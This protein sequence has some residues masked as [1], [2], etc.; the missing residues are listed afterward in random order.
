MRRYDGDQDFIAR[1]TEASLIDRLSFIKRTFPHVLMMGSYGPVFVAD[2]QNLGYGSE[3]IKSINHLVSDTIID[4]PDPWAS[5]DLIISNLNLQWVNDLPGFLWQIR[6]LLKPD[7]LFI[8]SLLGGD[9]LKELK[10]S[11]LQ[12]EMELYSGASA[13]VI[14]MVDLYSASQLLLRADFKL[15]VADRDMVK[16]SYP[17]LAKL[18][19]DLRAMGLTNVMHNRHKFMSSRRFFQRAEE[20]YSSNYSLQEGRIEATFEVIYL[21]GWSYHE[22][23][24]KAL[25]PGSAQ[26]SL[27]NMVEII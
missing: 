6:N 11:F 15:P 19:M 1:L 9:T 13:R 8:G 7:G 22:S 3:E 26:M 18:M 4:S 14:P 10:A 24:Q 5:Q 20:I 16:V 17:N 27:K 21:T 2:I 23:Q 25:K 12:A